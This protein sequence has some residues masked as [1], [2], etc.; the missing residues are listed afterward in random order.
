MKNETKTLAEL[1]RDAANSSYA[2]ILAA[3]ALVAAN[4]A[5]SAAA[6][7]AAADAAYRA[8]SA[9]AAAVHAAVYENIYTSA[10]DAVVY[11]AAADSRAEAV[12]AFREARAADAF[13]AA[14]CEA[15]AAALVGVHKAAR[16]ETTLSNGCSR[17][18]EWEVRAIDKHGD[19]IDVL[20]DA[21]LSEARNYTRVLDYDG[22]CVAIVIERHTSYQP[23]R[24]APGEADV[25]I[26]VATS[27]DADALKARGV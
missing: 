4:T 17:T 2:A 8:D 3:S 6:A 11:A 22:E 18:I 24:L 25:Y 23:A 9:A 7:A 12:L 5:Y 1:K 16:D 27:G 10:A 21:T 19:T 14:A 15:A 26:V 20:L 13:C